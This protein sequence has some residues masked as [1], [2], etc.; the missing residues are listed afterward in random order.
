[1]GRSDRLLLDF[2]MQSWNEADRRA[3]QLNPWKA[4]HGFLEYQP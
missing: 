4:D 2:E 3:Y 1:M